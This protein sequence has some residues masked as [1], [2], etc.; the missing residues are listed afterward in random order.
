MYKQRPGDKDEFQA[1]DVN[2][3]MNGKMSFTRIERRGI[4]WG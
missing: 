1:S 4:G 3:W 2:K